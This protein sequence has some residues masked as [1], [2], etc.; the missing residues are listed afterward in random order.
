MPWWSWSISAED[1]NVGSKLRE[2]EGSTCND[3]YAL[4]GMYVFPSVKAAHVRRKASLQNPRFV[5]A[6]T[7]LLN[8]KFSKARSSD[9]AFRWF[10]AGDL[11]DL[12]T[13]EKINAIALGTPQIKHWLPTRELRVVKAFIDKHGDFA[14]NL[15]VR[16]SSAMV[17][18]RF[19][20]APYGL[21]FSTV[22]RTDPDIRQCPAPK[23]NNECGDCRACWGT[24]PV[25]YSLH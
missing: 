21:A 11:P 7:F 6:F 22:G 20:K 4:K 12:E 23:Q 15:T 3:C 1:C 14:P 13:L 5:E 10:D 18:A 24:D 9:P 25:N 17:G 2:I 8:S 19:M 16:I